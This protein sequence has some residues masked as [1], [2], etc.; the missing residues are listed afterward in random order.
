MFFWSVNGTYNETAISKYEDG[1]I[2][3]CIAANIIK[4]SD[5]GCYRYAILENSNAQGK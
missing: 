1:F 4:F 5:S 2:Q 3:G